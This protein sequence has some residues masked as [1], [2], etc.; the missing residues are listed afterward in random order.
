[1]SPP[2]FSKILTCVTPNVILRLLGTDDSGDDGTMIQSHSQAESLKALAIYG[3]E[4]L[5]ESYRKVD[6]NDHVVLLRS[7]RVLREIIKR[8]K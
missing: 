3:V 5:H 4:C 8:E 7:L 1:M 6:Q 2:R